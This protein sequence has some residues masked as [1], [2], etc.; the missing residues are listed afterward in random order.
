[1]AMALQSP[2]L[3]LSHDS[4]SNG[5]LGITLN[6]PQRP[7]SQAAPKL[8]TNIRM[9]IKRW[10]RKEVKENSLPVVKK[11]HVKIGDTVKVIAGH[12]KGKI[13]T[14]T[15]LYTHNSKIMLKDV[16]LK[17]KHVKGKAEGETGQ[18][19]QVEAPIHSSNVMLYSKTA[20]VASRVGHKTLE[21]GSRVRY[22]LKTGEVIDSAEEWKKVHKKEEKKE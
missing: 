21:D 5:F 19:V 6:A 14:V 22:L 7:A 1:M 2:A 16:N 3:H 10:E 8:G 12:D 13:S 9:A 11:L 15:Q 20:K 18:I 4:L 17:T